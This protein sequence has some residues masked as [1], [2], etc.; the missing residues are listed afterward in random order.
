MYKNKI[1]L[2][3][4]SVLIFILGISCLNAANLDNGT[5]DNQTRDD[6]PSLQGTIGGG[7]DGGLGSSKPASPLGSGLGGGLGGGLGSSKPASPL[8]SGLGGGLGGGL[9]SS[10]PEPILDDNNPF[11]PLI[12]PTINDPF[13]TDPVLQ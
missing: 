6:S 10:F 7:L 8:G 4:V 13:P 3:L 1:V 9:G 2:I 12:N 11:G 5:A